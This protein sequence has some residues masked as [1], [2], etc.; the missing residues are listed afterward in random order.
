[1]NKSVQAQSLIAVRDVQ[2]SN[3]WYATLLGGEHMGGE[4]EASL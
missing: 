3:R 2:A 1:M 4:H